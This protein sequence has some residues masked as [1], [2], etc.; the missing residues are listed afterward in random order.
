M[1]FHEQP[2]KYLTTARGKIAYREA[3][4]PSPNKPTLVL[5]THLSATL[6]NWDPYLIDL[7]AQDRHVVTLD[8]YGIGSSTGASA[9]TIHQMAQGIAEYLEC[10]NLG[11]VDLIGMSMGGFVAQELAIYYPELIRKLILVGTGPAGG[12]GIALVPVITV[13]AILRGL[14]TR[15]DPRNYLFFPKQVRAKMSDYFMRQLTFVHPDTAI[16]PKDF[17]KQLF[18]ITRW[19]FQAP[20]NLS[21]IKHPTLVVNGDND[22]M[23]PTNP[24]TFELAQR[25]PNA[26]MAELYL[27]AGH[28]PLFQEPERF[29]KKAS[30]FLDHEGNA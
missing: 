16:T 29:A 15:K 21:Q 6:D 2:I 22:I 11:K 25:I 4:V 14:L 19:G 12:K 8:Y 1:K 5:L 3:G 20:Q 10:S 13:G 30:N 18:A 23:V 9:T 27:G 28:A 24:N 26:I 7:L 17:V